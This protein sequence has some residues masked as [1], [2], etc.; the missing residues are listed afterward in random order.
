MIS[1]SF[2]TDKLASHGIRFFTGV[3]DSLL[4]PLCAW[5][6]ANV[7]PENNVIAANEGGAMALATG[8]FLVTRDPACVYMQ[9]SGIGNSVNPLLSLLDADVYN[10]PV[11]LVIGWRGMPGFHDEP[12]HVKQGRVTPALLD[13]MEI[14]YII[15]SDVESIASEQLDAAITY[16]RE[17]GRQ[18]AVIVRK[19][20]FS[21]FKASDDH[22]LPYP[23]REDAI[24]EIVEAIDPSTAIV[25]TTGMISRELFELRETRG[26][27]HGSDFLTVGSMGHASQIALGIALDDKRRR[28]A[29]LDGDGA[30]LMH[31][32]GT[33][34]IGNRR[35]ENLIHFVINNGAHDSVGGQ[36]TVALEIDIPAIALACGYK[37]ACRIDSLNEIN[38]SIKAAEKSSGPHLIEIRVRKGARPDLGRP[39]TTPLENRDAFIHFLQE[40]H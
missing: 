11:L 14:P 32:G 31:L 18:M 4:K 37:T 19:N 7:P 26:E 33:A 40:K 9:N 20:T 8:H 3:P 16:I 12:Q 28:V 6:K 13:A 10:I 34:I 15:L 2:F 25:S 17:T 5:L 21:P 30:F 1:P 39:T 27:G 29:C 38:D 35:P 36:D 23:C 22:A 24:K